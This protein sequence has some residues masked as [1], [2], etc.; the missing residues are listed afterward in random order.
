MS[1]RQPYA[2]LKLH[3]RYGPVVRIAPNELSFNRAQSWQDIYTV[4][5]GALPF[6]KSEFYEGGNFAAEALSIVSERDP[7]RHARMR[8]Y[9]SNAFSDRSLKEQEPLIQGVVDEL[10]AK[11]AAFDAQGTDMVMWFNLA[12][13]DIIGSLAFGE[14]FGGV[15]SGT[16]H[17]WIATV[18]KSLSKGALGDCAKR[19]PALAKVVMFV[20][21]KPIDKLLAETRAHERNSK[22]LVQRRIARKTE[23]K[24]FMTNIL[25]ARAT[26]DISDTQIA[27]H[28]SDF[29]IAGSET[30]A[31]A[32]ACITYYLLRNPAITES[33]RAEIDSAFN[34]YDSINASSTAGLRYLNAV[35]QEGMR[36][37]PPLPFALPRVVPPGGAMV[38]GHWLPAGIIV[39]TAPFAASMDSRNFHEPW[40]FKPER[41]LDAKLREKDKQDASQ[42][43]SL[44]PRGCMGRSMGWM[45]LRIILAK[46]HWTYDLSL[47]N[48]DLDWHR[49][50]RMHTLWKKPELRVA[51]VKRAR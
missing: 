48:Q 24:D 34:S 27:A 37:Y 22:E 4:R 32:L 35:C 16:Q 28:A 20:L 44:G 31:T 18:I 12:T 17:P 30:T 51:L 9:L 26:D 50:S 38:D 19:F 43:F 1:G 47:V 33:L 42:P 15:A 41:W 46:L 49:D 21:A 2:I 6:I 7:E 14:T 10:I 45:E 29:V 25:E 3:E 5:H 39:S 40:T 23:R 8:R 13:F 36:M 11:L